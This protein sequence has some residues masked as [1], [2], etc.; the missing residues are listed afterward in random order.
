MGGQ[1][2]VGQRKGDERKGDELTLE[3]E[4]ADLSSCQGDDELLLGAAVLRPGTVVDP[5]ARPAR[6]FSLRAVVDPRICEVHA[7]AKPA[8]EAFLK[9]F[10]LPLP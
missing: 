8:V 6:A 5:G 9:P 7:W 4:A 10:G 2:K 3:R 1:R